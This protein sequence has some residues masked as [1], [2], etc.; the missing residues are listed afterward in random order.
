MSTQASVQKQLYDLPTCQLEVWSERSPLSE[1]SDRPIAQNLRFCLTID[2]RGRF[3]RV[4]QKTIKGNQNLLGK[5]VEAVAD[6][7]DKFLAEDNFSSLSHHLS[8]PN[9]SKLN[10]LNLTTLQLFDLVSSLEQCA[11]EVTILPTVELEVKRVTPAW[12]KIA[13]SV[14]ATVGVS[15]SAVKLIFDRP[16]LEIVTSSNHNTGVVEPPPQ[17]NRKG[18][19]EIISDASPSPN[20]NPKR[21]LNFAPPAPRSQSPTPIAPSPNTTTTPSIKIAEQSP[22]PAPHRQPSEPESKSPSLSPTPEVGRD[23]LEPR[24]SNAP[25]PPLGDTQPIRRNP[26]APP[27]SPETV[28]TPKTSGSFRSDPPSNAATSENNTQNSPKIAQDPLRKP[29]PIQSTRPAEISPPAPISPAISSPVTPPNRASTSGKVSQSRSAESEDLDR[30]RSSDNLPA[31]QAGIVATAGSN[32]QI[33]SIETTLSDD[34]KTS[35]SR[36]IKTTNLSDKV[37]GELVFDIALD[38]GKVTQ[39]KL[40]APATTLKNSL[41]VE[42]IRRSLLN[43][44][45]PASANGKIRLRL[46]V[47]A[48]SR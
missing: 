22:Q 36:H 1:W 10:R 24:Q 12:L 5:I 9:A 31:P 28:T 47:Q 45:V 18:K 27:P 7:A 11:I 33:A 34:I 32:I 14:I 6:Y 46:S 16:A 48:S 44:Q 13:A 3:G 19:K 30:A 37:S 42:K 2:Q 35:L 39:V 43:W 41:V 23:A 29:S 26:I 15:T 4:K 38:R 21:D 20:A 8:I 25:E 40:D 17:S